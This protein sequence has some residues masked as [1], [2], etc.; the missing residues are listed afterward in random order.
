MEKM[1]CKNNWNAKQ[2]AMQKKLFSGCGRPAFP[3]DLS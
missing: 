3:L 2:T 1:Q